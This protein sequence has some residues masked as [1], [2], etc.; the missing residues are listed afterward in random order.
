MFA[1]ALPASTED[2]D[3]KGNEARLELS[4]DLGIGVVPIIILLPRLAVGEVA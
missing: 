3:E 2:D 4:V 1:L